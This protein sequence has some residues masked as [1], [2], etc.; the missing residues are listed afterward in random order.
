MGWNP[1][2]KKHK[3]QTIGYRYYWDIHSGLGRG[4]VDEIVEVRVDD[5]TAYSTKAGE[6]TQNCAIFIDKPKLFGGDD[7]GG[8]GGVQ[9]RMEFFF[10]EADQKPSLMLNS[11]LN[12]I[13]Q[14]WDNN[15]NTHFPTYFD[16]QGNIPCFRGIVST[17][18]SGM[19]SC[20]SAYPKKHSYRV[21]RTLKGWTNNKVWYPEKC[22]IIL[23]NENI[24]LSNLS[25]EQKANAVEIQ[26]MNPAH[27]L[28]ECATNKSWGGKKEFDDLDLESFK[29][30]ADTLY[31]E[32]FGLCFRYNRQNSIREFIQEILDHISAVQYE[33]IET[34]KL[35][36]KLIRNDYKVNELPLFNYDNGILSV[37]EEDTGSVENAPNQIIVTYR[38]PVL[39]KEQ[40]VI[41]NNLASVRIYGVISKKQS[42]KGIPT[43]E[44]ASRAAMRDLELASSGLIRLKIRMDNRGAHFV[45]GDVFRINLPDRGIQN[46]VLRVGNITNGN[47]GEF[48]VTCIQDVFGM[49]NVSYITQPPPIL[50]NPANFTAKPVEKVLLLEMPYVFLCHSFDEKDIQEEIKDGKYCYMTA[51]AALPT[52]ETLG[53]DLIANTEGLS[54]ERIELNEQNF[55][56]FFILKK[57]LEPFSTTLPL[58]EQLDFKDRCI[59]IGNEILK[60]EAFDEKKMQITV[61]RGCADTIPQHHTAGALAWLVKIPELE[62]T[63]YEMDK[64]FSVKL[65]SFTSQDSLEQEE[66]QAIE[67]RS[68]NR[69][70]RPYPPSKVQVNGKFVNEINTENFTITWEH[71]NKEEQGA[72]LIDHTAIGRTLPIGVRYKIDL[73]KNEQITRSIETNG[74]VFTYPDSKKPASEQIDKIR[75]YAT[76]ESLESL[77]KYEF[78]V[79]NNYRKK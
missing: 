51:L 23:R 9:G 76:S 41:V 73:I 46:M 37:Q 55:T 49:P 18:Y 50:S 68:R 16:S 40:Q 44:L 38:D 52:P 57:D 61:G 67:F 64:R 75:L 71:R 10:G 25:E 74:K 11:L 60:I 53:F 59:V 6:I 28:V 42:Y 4:P 32:E 5:K 58:F 62:F 56:N 35:A 7:T 43:F 13:P 47:E 45:P 21:R 24:P 70:S 72:K 29:K 8:E 15:R 30:A 39:N 36:I 79:K 17:C 2:K 19:I 77:Q 31:K 63:E 14:Q 65:L 27:I 20:F 1:F 34:G 69:L 78:L 54:L 26:A 66:A 22:R 33:N 3:P 12:R 48:I